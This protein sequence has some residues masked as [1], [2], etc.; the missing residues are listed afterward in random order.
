[1]TKIAYFSYAESRVIDLVAGL[2]P[3]GFEVTGRSD[4][5]SDGDKIEIIGDADFLMLHGGR[6]S[7]RVLRAGTKIKLLQLLSAGYD[8][9]DLELMNELK[10]PVA[11]VGGANRQGVAELTITLI[12]AVL[13]RLN[14]METGLKAGKWR[15]ELSSGLDTFELTE[16]TVG[17]IGFG[18][19]GQTVAQ[20]L[21]GFD[22]RILY[23]DVTA[24]PQVERELGVSRVSLDE[25]LGEADIVT[26]HTPLLPETRRLIGKR[27]LSLMKPTAVLINTARG[28]VLDEAALI[29]ALKEETIWGAGLDVFERE[30]ISRDNPLLSMENVV[31]SPHAAGGTYESWPRR[32]SFAYENFQRVLRG[33][34]PLSLVLS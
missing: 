30:P 33:E 8:N 24:Y 32:A 25:L 19:I 7:E 20:L 34:Q 2:V 10:I 14:Q 21:R 27:E 28:E 18:M 9:V 3:K 5:I 1:M 29:S 12:L 26:V 22:T 6:Q 16:K 31:L 23:S 15:E 11:N 4:G 13:R 17:I